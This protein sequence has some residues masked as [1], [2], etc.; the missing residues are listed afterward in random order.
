[1]QQYPLKLALTAQPTPKKVW[2]AKD[3]MK[4]F[5]IY[6]VCINMCSAGVTYAIIKKK[7]MWLLAS[8]E[9]KSH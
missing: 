7:Y 5:I 8:G 4:S 6:I 3:K 2:Q 1:M 9:N